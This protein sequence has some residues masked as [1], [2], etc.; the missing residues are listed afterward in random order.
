[1]LSVYDKGLNGQQAAWASRKYR[2]HRV[3]PQSL[4]NDLKKA[5]FNCTTILAMLLVVKYSFLLMNSSNC[6]TCDSTMKADYTFC[7]SSC[8]RVDYESKI[9]QAQFRS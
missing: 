6:W 5:T 3:L 7:P 1:I 2:G 4:M 9:T 8:C